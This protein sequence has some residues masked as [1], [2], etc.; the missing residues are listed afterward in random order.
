M[1]T[2][3]YIVRMISTIVLMIARLSGL[4]TERIYTPQ[5]DAAIDITTLPSLARRLRELTEQGEI[6]Q[7]ENLLFEEADFT[8]AEDLSVALD[9]YTHLNT[10]SREFLERCDYSKEELYEGLLDCAAKAGIDPALLED[11][12]QYRN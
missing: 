5:E 4:K 10:Y 6:N 12:S 11:F 7:A 3:D 2:D 8:R 9:F 1:I